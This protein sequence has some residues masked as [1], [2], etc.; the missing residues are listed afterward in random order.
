M[1][2]LVIGCPVQFSKPNEDTTAGLVIA[3]HED[4]T[5]DLIVYSAKKKEW[6][7][8]ANIPFALASAKPY[9]THARP[10]SLP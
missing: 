9:W 4:E 2:K 6:H 7:V 5:V 1:D 8:E 3:V 10:E